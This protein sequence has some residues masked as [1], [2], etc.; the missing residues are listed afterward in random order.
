MS[1]P[2]EVTNRANMDDDIEAIEEWESGEEAGEDESSDS[3]SEMDQQSEGSSDELPEIDDISEPEDNISIDQD[4]DADIESDFSEEE[5]AESAQISDENLF[6][7]DM[8]EMASDVPV[9][10]VAVIGK[11]TVSIGDVMKYNI[12]SIVD[13]K[14]SPNEI[15]DVVANGKLIAKGELVEIDGKL[16]VKILKLLK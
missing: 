15:V 14:R 8:A 2:D 10:L 4:D 5:P 16:G 7:S 12:G 9:K 11:I 6:S 13:L 1:K 3:G